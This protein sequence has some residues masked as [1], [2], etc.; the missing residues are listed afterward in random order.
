MKKSLNELESVFKSMDSAKGKVGLDL[1][2]EIQFMKKTLERLRK[3]IDNKDII[4][5]MQQG[6]Y[7]IDRSNP[8]L[9]TYNTTIGNYNKLMK[10]L[11]DLLPNNEKPKDDGFEG[12]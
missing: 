7:S 10:Q 3:E 9:K 8:A 11:T 2:V 1:L 12:F 4:L 6:E 5:E